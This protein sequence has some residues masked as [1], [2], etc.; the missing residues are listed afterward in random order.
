MCSKEACFDYF[1]ACLVDLFYGFIPAFVSLAS[2]IDNLI[3]PDF[4]AAL[5]SS[6]G[7]L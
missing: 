4:D 1:D 6:F 2:S 5:V 7:P 3:P